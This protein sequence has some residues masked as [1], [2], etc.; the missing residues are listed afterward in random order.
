MEGEGSMDRHRILVGFGAVLLLSG[1]ISRVSTLLINPETNQA[2]QCDRIEGVAPG[3]VSA[4]YQAATNAN[5]E[6]CIE[7]AKRAGFIMTPKSLGTDFAVDDSNRIKAVRRDAE[8]SGLRVG[9]KVLK[10]DNFDLSL[11]DERRGFL[12]HLNSKA[13][14]DPITVLIERDGTQMEFSVR[15]PPAD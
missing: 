2:V 14:G 13:V 11:P 15:L 4:A 7:N 8:R 6:Q 1:C 5:Y 9:D 12:E 3:G 10:V